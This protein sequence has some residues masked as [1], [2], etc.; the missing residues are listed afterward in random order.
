[1]AIAADDEPVAIGC[2]SEIGGLLLDIAPHRGKEVIEPGDQQWVARAA[3]RDRAIAGALDPFELNGIGVRRLPAHPADADRA[4]RDR[5]EPAGLGIEHSTRLD[6][7]NR[8]RILVQAVVGDRERGAP[9]LRVER[10][11][12]D[13]VVTHRDK[14]TIVTLGNRGGG[15]AFEHLAGVPRLGRRQLSAHRR[16]RPWSRIAAAP[17]QHDLRAIVWCL[18]ERFGAHHGDD[19]FGPL[20]RRGVER[21]PMGE[22]ADPAFAHAPRDQRF[23]LLGMDDR[24]RKVETLL[25]GD[26]AH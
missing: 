13:M 7:V 19:A 1:M 2:R 24:H 18:Y 26:L 5:L 6:V 15:A 22:G 23:V 8:A 25:A 16:G 14:E 17:R 12:L 4:V 21:R 10:L 20:D 3:D 11:A 9:P